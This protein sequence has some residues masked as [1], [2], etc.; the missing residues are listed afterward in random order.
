[1]LDLLR[2]GIRWRSFEPGWFE[3]R[4]DSFVRLM[5]GEELTAD[6]KDGSSIAARLLTTLDKDPEIRAEAERVLV[7]YE[8]YVRARAGSGQA[9]TDD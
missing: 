5:R 6:G 9:T 3:E 1:L 7:E 2:V 4:R 8:A